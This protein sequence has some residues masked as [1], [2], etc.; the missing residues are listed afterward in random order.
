MLTNLVSTADL[1]VIAQSL[2]NKTANLTV[3]LKMI[4]QECGI[5]KTL[6][7]GKQTS[8][9][10][11]NGSDVCHTLPSENGRGKGY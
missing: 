10:L 3:P 8:H 9:D 5:A 6:P 7:L 4:T 1:V 11:T 2:T